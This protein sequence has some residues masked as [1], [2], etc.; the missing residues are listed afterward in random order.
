VI[1]I[2][3]WDIGGANVKAAWLTREGNI[4]QAVK[5]CNAEFRDLAG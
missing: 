3:G 1:S 2:V 5:S 4:T